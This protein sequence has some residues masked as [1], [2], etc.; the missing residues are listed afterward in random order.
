MDIKNKF[1]E[2]K[3][4]ISKIERDVD[5]FCNKNNQAAGRRIRIAMQLIR[6]L[7]LEIRK[8]ISELK[9]NRKTQKK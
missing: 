7:A 8:T 3:D 1:I 5:S 4:L 2:I 9:K 6:K